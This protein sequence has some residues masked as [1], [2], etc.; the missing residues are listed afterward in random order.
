MRNN[1]RLFIN[2]KE[3]EFSSN[4]L[5][6]LN[7]KQSELSCPTVVRN[8]FTKQ[9]TIQGTNR[10][11]DI[12]GH[13]WNLERVQ[14]DNFNPIRK[15]D[16]QLFVNDDLYQKGYCKLDKV[17][18]TTN[19]IEYSLTLYG[20][21]GSFFYNLTY[22]QDDLSNAKKTLASLKYTTEWELEEPQLEFTIDKDTVN[23]AWEALTGTGSEIPDDK[24]KVI[25]FIPCLNGIPSDFSANKVLINYNGIDTGSSSGF[26][27]QKVV[28]GVTYKTVING[29][30]HTNGYAMAETSQ[31]LQEWQTR[32]LRSYNQRPCISM[33]RII[34]ACCQPENNGGYKVELDPHFFHNENPYYE[35]AWVTL[36]MLKD[37]EGV[38]GGE[39]Y[40]I[41]GA[42]ISSQS[43][44]QY[45][46]K[47]YPVNFTAPTL[48]TL[49]NVTMNV[50]VRFRPT[51]SQANTNLY[52][53]HTYY[54]KASTILGSTYVR[55]LEENQGIIIQLFAFGAGGEVV[56][57]SKAY[58]LGGNKTWYKKSNEAMWSQFWTGNKGLMPDY[59]VE[60]EYEYIEGY[61]QKA[62]LAGNEYAFCDKNG[63]RMD[64]NFSFNA[65][66][67]FV[68]LIMKVEQPHG[69]YIKYAFT[70][71]FASRVPNDSSPVLYTSKHYSTTG[72]HYEY[73][74][75]TQDSVAG[76][77]G[78]VV[79]SMDAT[80]TDYEGFFSGT[81]ISKERLLTT[82]KTPADYLLSYCKM[83]GL[84]FYHD[85]TEEA[86][87]PERYPSGVVHI[88]DR[89]TFYTEEVVDLSKLI[90]WNKKVEIVPA[91][92]D[93]KWYKFDVEH[94]ESELDT[95]YKQ[96][97]GKDYGAQLV[98]TN[99]NFDSNTTNLYDGNAFKTG[100]MAL[101]K[102]KYYKRTSTGLPVYQ[103]NGLTYTLY[104]R[105]NTTDEFSTTD[106][107]FPITTTMHMESV[108]PDYEFYDA[109]PKLQLHGEGNDAVD[110][111]GILVFLKYHVQTDADYWLTDDLLDMAVLNDGSPCWIMTKSETNAVGDRIARKVNYF[112]YFT[113]DLVPFAENYGNI[114]HSWNFGHP[115]VIYVP[116]TYST[117]GDS[118][119]DVCWRDYMRDLYS[120][121]TRKLT[122]YVRAEFDGR[123]WPYWLRRY[124]WFENSI[125]RLNE[126]KDLNVGSFDTTKMEFIKVQDMDDYK[127]ERIT[128]IGSNHLEMLDKTLAC[129]GGVVNGQV[130]LQAAGSWYASDVLRGE[131]EDGN[132]IYLDMQ[133]YMS[134]I[135]G[136]GLNITPFTITL[137]ANTGS[138][139]ITWTVGAIDGLDN[140][141]R[142]TFVQEACA[143][144]SLSITP[145][146]RTVGKSSGSTTYTISSS[147]ITGLSVSTL[148]SWTST[149]RLGNLVTVNYQA[150]PTQMDRID[151]VTVTGYAPNGRQASATA[152][153][154][155]SGAT[156]SDYSVDYEFTFNEFAAQDE[157]SMKITIASDILT[158]ETVGYISSGAE[159]EIESGIISVRSTPGADISI[160]I[161]N[162][163]ST[164]SQLDVILHYGQ[165]SDSLL[166]GPGDI[167]TITA[168]FSPDTWIYVDVWEA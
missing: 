53:Y 40:D 87:D 158:S 92:A 100:I 30:E 145:S 93:A 26:Y 45:G 116:D 69:E 91:M 124:Y 8:S 107:D 152:T 6:L 49:N 132:I 25:N 46:N 84:Y 60:P 14:D 75:R 21:L 13:I 3:I 161:E 94:V 89:D 52:P 151:Y 86:D 140:R 133:D 19:S 149:S 31:D 104:H 47:M 81:K 15:T 111:E 11:N 96:Q 2:G 167:I 39:T 37:L 142:D 43:S 41:T 54:S 56:G 148:S 123:P 68:S 32:D 72:N 165:T 108:N 1:I 118:I 110:G 36:G 97:F 80:A 115:Q 103:Y 127:L 105:E 24:W 129:T 159:E 139:P 33:R 128:Y 120:V 113:R 61:F 121:D 98:N 62:D 20:N 74:A 34:D 143:S 126:I 12:F 85:S 102:D 55:D 27:R 101:E 66:N 117:D 79:T 99:Y 95:G 42:T 146:G 83:F 155:Q 35:D 130:V 160:T 4:P 7:Y 150:N 29:V 125:W 163:D 90:D 122:C 23:D 63:V 76:Q 166:L 164:A 58:L 119:Y 71:S 82:D 44:Q 70:G 168:P 109:F 141:L 64:I 134:P 131:D 51:Q 78:F 10:N 114:S 154:V 112:P 28:D 38:Q 50:S 5:I 153:L 18:R 48:S 137:P 77:Y 67:D 88:M 73:E 22:D 147:N 138:T 16:F 144:Y 157:T 59:G 136:S 65:P 17:T 156:A 57:Q 9:V 106:I 135:S 162:V